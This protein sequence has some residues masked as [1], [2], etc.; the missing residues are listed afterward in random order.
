MQVALSQNT[1]VAL[2][3]VHRT[4]RRIEVYQSMEAFLDVHACTESEGATH[5]DTNL[6]G[7]DLVKDFKFLLHSHARFHHNNLLLRHTGSNQ[8]LAD[9]LI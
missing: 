2:C 5:N 1:S 6:T 3:V 9:I 7:I 4:V 8:F